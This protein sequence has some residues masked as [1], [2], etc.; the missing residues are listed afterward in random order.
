[1]RYSHN[2]PEIYGVDERIYDRLCRELE[3][4][5][6]DLH[7]EYS[8]SNPQQWTNLTMYL[9]QSGKFNIEYNYDEVLF[10]P[11]QQR[12]IWEYEILGL[13]PTDGFHQRYLDE[14]LKQKA[15]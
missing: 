11:S 5:F 3:E 6:V 12:T 15:N 8:K 14:Y 4:Y 10:S 13:H 7:A 2:I 1:M 9:S